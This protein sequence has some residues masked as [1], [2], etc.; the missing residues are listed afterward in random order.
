MHEYSEARQ[1]YEPRHLTRLRISVVV[2]NAPFLL[3]I[4]RGY[5]TYSVG[6]NEREHAA[7]EMQPTGTF[8][9]V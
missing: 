5:I 1:H 2:V 9:V 3:Y 4:A 8:L 7:S 6:R